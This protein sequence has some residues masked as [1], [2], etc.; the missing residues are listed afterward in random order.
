MMLTAL[1][2][3]LLH[4]IEENKVQHDILSHVKLLVPALASYDANG[5]NQSFKTI[6]PSQSQT[7]KDQS[8][9][10]HYTLPT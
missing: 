4:L 10:E 5:E 3:I 6:T 8:F 2:M 1:P 9:Q 7:I